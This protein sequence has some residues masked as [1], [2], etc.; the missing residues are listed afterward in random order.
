MPVGVFARVPWTAD[1]LTAGA[2]SRVG[3]GTEAVRTSLEQ[4]G[5][6]AEMAGN[7]HHRIFALEHNG[8]PR[9][10]VDKFDGLVREVMNLPTLFIRGHVMVADGD[11][12]LAIHVVQ[13]RDVV[14]VFSWWQRQCAGHDY[15]PTALRTA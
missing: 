14:F 12:L 5:V 15:A 9:R 2:A 7:D 1:T 3:R 10:A 4:A 8:A 13:D 6:S 11:D